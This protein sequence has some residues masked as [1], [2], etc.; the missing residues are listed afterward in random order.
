MSDAPVL[1]I[2]NLHANVEPGDLE[3]PL[4]EDFCGED[5]I[6]GAGTFYFVEN[7]PQKEQTLTSEDGLWAFVNVAPGQV[8]VFGSGRQVLGNVSRVLLED[9]TGARFPERP[10]GYRI[11]ECRCVLLKEK[12]FPCLRTVEDSLNSLKEPP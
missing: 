10:P 11:A 4:T 5:P 12:S 8:T 1:Q 7:F 2:K 6:Y 9:Q 3:A